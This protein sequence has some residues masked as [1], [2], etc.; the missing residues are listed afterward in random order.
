MSTAYTEPVLD[1]RLEGDI[2][3]DPLDPH[4]EV[5]TPLDLV[6]RL[7]R[8]D[9]ERRVERLTEMAW[10]RYEQAVAAC[11]SKTIEA[12]CGL[13]SGGKDSSAIVT[14]FRPVLTH[15]LH[16]DT[17]TGIEATR[18]F[19]RG[20]AAAWELP[21]VMERAPDDYFDIV[22]GLVKTKGT[23]EDVWPGGFPGPG[24]HGFTQQ[25][26]KERAMD[27][28]R[29]TLGVG[30]SKTRCVIWIAGR[31]RPES[32][33]RKDVP[34]VELDGSVTWSAPLAVW[35]KADL[36]TLRLMRPDEVPINP[37]AERLGMSGECGCLANAHPGER[38]M[39]FRNYPDDPFLAKVLEVEALLRDR[40]GLRRLALSRGYTAAAADAYADRLYAIPEHRKTWGWGA[41]HVDKTPAP[42]V[43]S[44]GR[45]CKKDCGV[46]PLLA[47]MDPLIPLDRV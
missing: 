29:H 5:P 17:G 36:L 27:L 3:H 24:A 30:N 23:G 11:G 25:R 45:L 21:L 15:L 19:V 7:T 39:W 42:R 18:E 14:L 10:A 4:P 40:A 26:L 44:V 37:T 8:R 20:V 13:Y 16:A 2:D 33:A 28:A 38:E 1:F 6:V 35:H 34:H 31:R 41:T 9:R 47:L 22:L 43:D 12:I 32:E 46:D